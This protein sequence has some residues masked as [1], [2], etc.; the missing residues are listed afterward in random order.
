MEDVY[1]AVIKDG[2]RDLWFGQFLI[3]ELLGRI[4][5][6]LSFSRFTKVRDIK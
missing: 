5:S 6:H 3:Y 2:S 4:D 1:A